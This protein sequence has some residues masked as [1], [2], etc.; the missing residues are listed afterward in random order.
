VRG[1]S[2]GGKI[3][4]LTLATCDI[5]DVLFSNSREELHGEYQREG[6]VEKDNHRPVWACTSHQASPNAAG[7]ANASVCVA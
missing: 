7:C 5:F 3:E 4:R 1:V 6:V 2:T